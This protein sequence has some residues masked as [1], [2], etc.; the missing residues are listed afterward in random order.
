[1]QA[2]TRVATAAARQR[3]AAD[4]LA[5]AAQRVADAAEIAYRRGAISLL[6]VLEARRSLRAAQIER[7][8]AEADAAKAAAE[9]D[10]ASFMLP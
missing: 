8:N 4:E 2:R 5:P 6:E 9:L 10:A 1:M 7:I 3:L